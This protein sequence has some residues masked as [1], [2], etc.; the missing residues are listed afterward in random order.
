MSLSAMGL[1]FAFNVIVFSPAFYPTANPIAIALFGLLLSLPSV[2]VYTLMSIAMPR[3]GGDYVWVSRIA[4]P[5]TGFTVNVALTLIPLAFVGIGTPTAVQWATAEMFYDLGKIYN[6]QG[7][8]SIATY[9][10][11]SDPTF[12]LAVVLILFAAAIVIAN[13][14]LA[15]RVVRYF[16]IIAFAVS[17]IFVGTVL[18][19]GNSAFISNFNA[20]SGANYNSVISA[21]QA[22]GAFSGVPDMFSLSSVYAGAATG[23]LA[24]LGF[25]YP[26]YFAGE[27]KQVRKTQ[28]IAQLGGIIIFALF[29]C[30]IV[31]VEYYGEGPSFVNAMAALWAAGSSSFP[32][33][34]IPLASGMSMF[35]TQNPFLVSLFNL[36]YAATVEVFN[37]AVFFTLSRNLFAWSFDRVMPMAFASLNEKTRTPLN[38][39][40]P[41]VLVS[42]VYTYIAVYQYGILASYFSYGTAGLVI[43]MAIVALIA[44][45]YPYRRRD[46]F[47]A[48]DPMSKRR[49]LGVP[50]ISIFGVLTVITAAIIVYAIILPV[51]GGIQF[52][53]IF[54]QGIIPT[55]V[56]GAVIYIIAKV[57]RR[58]QGIDIGLAQREIPPE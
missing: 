48:A 42:I 55:F 47:E 27:V 34:A 51:I 56:I 53:T 37:I 52:E 50:L 19:A 14:R 4:N 21:G 17:V 30:V 40:I 45:V 43:G 28:I 46:I 29:T 8:L 31:A 13:V 57:V 6:N 20:L 36:S 35:W 12:W 1:L 38:A 33:V 54:T 39:T 15:T 2:G 18:A 16:T 5:M 11:G 41:M 49:I 32:Y 24:Y 7:Y 9:L 25:Y 22:A 3:T 26:A 10:Q 44:I 23:A 58:K